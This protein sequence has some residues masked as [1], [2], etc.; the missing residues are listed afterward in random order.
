MYN[1]IKRDFILQK[2]LL[3]IFI[4]I[5]VLFII[6][7]KHPV[8]IFLVASILIPFNTLTYDEKA[9]TNILLNSLPYTR[10]EVIAS[11]YLGAIIYMLGAIGV[12]SLLLLIFNKPF[13][14]ADM[15]LGCGLF[16]LFATFTFPLF[17]IFKP[18]F[19]SSV[20]LICFLLAVFLGP[21]IIS[22]LTEHFTA[23][24]QFLDLLPTP[25][26]YTGAVMVVLTLYAVSWGVTTLLYQ[27]KAF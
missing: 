25:V 18:G 22:F 7:E 1:L 9:E 8:L 16:L 26:L 15:A 13:S 27:R 19:I 4:P 3:F 23:I 10:K 2:K 21:Y 11:R 24:T 12:T 17:Y 20:V 6:M 5:I 14:V